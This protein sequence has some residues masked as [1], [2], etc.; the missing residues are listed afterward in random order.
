MHRRK[1]KH[2]FLRAWSIH[3]GSHSPLPCGRVF[4]QR[5]GANMDQERR[6]FLQDSVRLGG[7]ALASAALWRLEPV[8]AQSR[9]GHELGTMTMVELSQLLAS[10][11]I[12]SRRGRPAEQ[13]DELA[14]LHVPSYLGSF[15]SN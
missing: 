12:T 2:K 6:D 13:R 11:K 10:Q 15:L 9:R 8:L 14:A 7:V 3:A 4:L 1:E 5:G